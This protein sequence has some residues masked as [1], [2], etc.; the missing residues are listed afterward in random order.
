MENLLSFGEKAVGLNFNPSEGEINE[1]VHSAK[2]TCAD[3][4]DM[5]NEIRARAA[6]TEGDGLYPLGPSEE[7]KALCT[8]AIRK[9]QSAQM[10]MV[11]A[12]TWKD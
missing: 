1:H 2:K 9:L 6:L 3:A 4:I 11:K 10:D 7:R 8:I 12:I 5:M